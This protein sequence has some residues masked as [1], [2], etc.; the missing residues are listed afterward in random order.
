MAELDFTTPPRLNS[1]GET[2]RRIEAERLAK[3]RE[4]Q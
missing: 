1:F 4:N 2:I 3:A